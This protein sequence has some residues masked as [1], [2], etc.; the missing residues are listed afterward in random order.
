MRGYRADKLGGTAI[1]AAGA[2][3]IFEKNSRD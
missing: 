3:S 1:Q 2:A